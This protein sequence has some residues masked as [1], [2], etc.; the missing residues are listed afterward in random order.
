MF[1]KT[2]VEAAPDKGIPDITGVVITF[3]IPVLEAT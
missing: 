2:G 3:E 1:I